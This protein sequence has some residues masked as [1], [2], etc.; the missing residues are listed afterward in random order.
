MNK[1]KKQKKNSKSSLSLQQKQI[2][3]EYFSFSKNLPHIILCCSLLFTVACRLRLL[4]VPLERDEGEYAYVG[5]QLLQGVPP[6][7]S[8][9]H[10]K[11][12]GIYTAYAIIEFLFGE[13]HKGIH[14]GLLFVNV[15][16]AIVVFFTGKRFFNPLYA[17]L[18]AACFCIFSLS[19]KFLGF[20]ANAEH[21]VVLP[22]MIG[23]LFLLRSFEA[24]KE[25]KIVSGKD[26][27][28]RLLNIASLPL[29]NFFVAGLFLG[30]AYTMKQHGIFF[31]AFAGIFFLY[32]WFVAKPLNWKNFFVNGFVFGAGVLL[33]LGVLCLIFLKLGLFDKFWWWTWYYPRQY[34]TQISWDAGMNYLGFSF[35]PMW[36]TFW[37]LFVLAGAG[38]IGLVK[39]KPWDSKIFVIGLFAFTV[40]ALSAG[41]YFYPHYFIHATPALGLLVAAGAEFISNFFRNSNKGFLKNYLGASVLIIFLFSAIKNEKDYYFNMD[42]ISVVRSSYHGNPFPE[43]LEIAKYIE[44]NT[45][46]EDK[47]AVIGSEPQIYFYAKR[48]AATGFMYTYEMMKDHPHVHEFQTTMMKEIEEAKPKMILYVYVTSSWFA[49]PLKNMDPYIFDQSHKYISENYEQAGI[50]NIIGGRKEG[51]YCWEDPSK[52]GNE[53]V[54]PVKPGG[55][56]WD[57]LW[58]AVYKRKEAVPAIKQ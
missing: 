51:V 41:F 22:A 17:A 36:E 42:G 5:Q 10:V 13:T 7:V 55:S 56:P 8:I 9:Y 6:F 20:S 31:I 47:I 33:P 37:L 21:F 28:L 23:I 25:R 1:N 29:F 34:I 40:L 39:D 24:V 19:Q 53:C 44:K 54:A 16:T 2:S 3:S 14:F 35:K 45:S 18:A 15:L 32:K 50:V 48:R 4:E 43:S 12:P 27:K 30:T 58:L 11:L 52:P 26:F 46:P 49:T 57:A 38:I